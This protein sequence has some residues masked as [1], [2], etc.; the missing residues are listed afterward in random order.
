MP[1][2]VFSQ[3]DIDQWQQGGTPPGYW[4]IGFPTSQDAE[5]QNR[6]AEQM[7]REKEARIRREAE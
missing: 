2:L 5:E 3:T 6:L 4:S 7:T 1:I